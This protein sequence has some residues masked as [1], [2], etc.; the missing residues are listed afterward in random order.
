M[1]G[2][3]DRQIHTDD[4]NLINYSLLGQDERHLGTVI[5]VTLH[6]IFSL[7]RTDIKHG[8]SGEGTGHLPSTSHL[9]QFLSIVMDCVMMHHLDAAAEEINGTELNQIK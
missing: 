9:P 4:T 2:D 3:M 8:Q 5:A 6:G 7:T 1:A